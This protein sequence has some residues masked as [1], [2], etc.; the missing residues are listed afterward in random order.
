MQKA[1][2]TACDW[3]NEKRQSEE[4]RLISVFKDAGLTIT[5]PDVEAFRKHV[6][7]YYLNSDRSKDWPKGLIEEI[8]KL[9]QE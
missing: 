1:A 9:A 2:V 6:Q 4:A 7:S 3:N 8:N 5:S